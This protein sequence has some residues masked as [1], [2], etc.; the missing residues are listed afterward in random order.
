M[1]YTIDPSTT[2]YVGVCGECGVRTLTNT[3]A[4]AC[5]A[6]DRHQEEHHMKRGRQAKPRAT[7]RP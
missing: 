5:A 3:R 1:H 7:R 6:R 4:A 2:S